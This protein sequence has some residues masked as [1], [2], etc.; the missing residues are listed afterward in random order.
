LEVFGGRPAFLRAEERA[1]SGKNGSRFS[2]FILVS[3]LPSLADS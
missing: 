1:Y 3:E 2:S